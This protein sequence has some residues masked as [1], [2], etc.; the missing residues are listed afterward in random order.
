MPHPSFFKISCKQ[1]RSHN[2]R[3]GFALAI[4]LLTLF[5]LGVIGA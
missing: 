1:P 5:L 4:V 3:A 2:P